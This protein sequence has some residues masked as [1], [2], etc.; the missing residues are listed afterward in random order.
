M[1][2]RGSPGSRTFDFRNCLAGNGVLRNH[3]RRIREDHRAV[4]SSRRDTS[5]H[6]PASLFVPAQRQLEGKTTASPSDHQWYPSRLV[7]VA[8]GGG[9]GGETVS[10]EHP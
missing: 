7:V 3:R 1:W 6:A 9:G 4:C 10:M 2:F 5:C 8:V